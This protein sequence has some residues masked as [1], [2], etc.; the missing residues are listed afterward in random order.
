M[1]DASPSIGQS[2]RPLASRPLASRPLASRPLA[3]RPLAS[4]PL[5]S[6]PLAPLVAPVVPPLGRRSVLSAL[7]GL[8]LSERTARAA[9]GAVP[10]APLDP[11]TLLIAGPEGGT[12]DHWGRTIQAPL[13]QGLRK[14][15]LRCAS[16]GG[17]DGV[18]AAN[19][20]A[21]RGMPDGMTALLAPSEAILAWMVGDPRAQYDV[22][23]W[24]PVMAGVTPGL[25]IFRPGTVASRKPVRIASAGFASPDLTAILGIDL[26]GAVAEPVAPIAPDALPAAFGRRAVDA[27][28]LRGHNVVAQARPFLDAGGL[29]LF[30]LGGH[31]ETGQHV[32]CDTFPEVPTL[33]EAYAAI[34]GPMPPGPLA[35]A[36]SAAAVA[37]QL[38]FTLVLPHLTPAAQVA[39]WR[40]AATEAAASMDVRALAQA[41][42]VRATGGADVTTA[43]HGAA[44]QQASLTALRQWLSGRFNWRPT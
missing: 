14:P 37:S 1:T 13:S 18:T 12:L 6:R 40:H 8:A 21:A 11:S 20:F 15:P 33:R 34:G 27:V 39:L 42:G 38:E 4:R 25:V 24:T 32:R 36:W 26:L 3:S 30:S 23:R 44:A 28:F 7:A 19:Q 16:V 5:A 22:A 29:P 43:A 31:D 2:S 41:F 17:A 10:V 9:P 35:D